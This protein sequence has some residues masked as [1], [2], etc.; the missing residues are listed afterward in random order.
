MWPAASAPCPPNEH[1]TLIAA[2]GFGWADDRRRSLEAGF[3]HHL[4]KPLALEDVEALLAGGRP[5]GA[6]PDGDT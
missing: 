5:S 4:V 2:T 1:I 6:R 3:D